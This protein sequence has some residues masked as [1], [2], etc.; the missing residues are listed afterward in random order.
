MNDLWDAL[1]NAAAM[2]AA[3]FSGWTVF[4]S[5]V[6]DDLQITP[7]ADGR[8]VLSNPG[9]APILVRKV[10][11]S[12]GTLW[13]TLFCAKARNH[14]FGDSQATEYAI[15]LFVP[16]GG[17]R[18][19]PV[20]LGIAGQLQHLRGKPRRVRFWE[21]SVVDVVLAPDPHGISPRHP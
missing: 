4:R 10:V 20:G 19:L 8:L 18:E 11:C 15:A 21:P 16:A 7:R 14:V 9:A 6:Q 3:L 17:S 5:H 1:G 2:L 12:Q 13:R